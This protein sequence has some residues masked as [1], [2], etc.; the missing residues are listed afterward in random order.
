MVAGVVPCA[1]K[2]ARNAINFE[3]L[4][5][6]SGDQYPNVAAEGA[7]ETARAGV[8]KGSP[9]DCFGVFCQVG[10]L[11]RYQQGC[12]LALISWMRPIDTIPEKETLTY[13]FHHSVQDGILF[14]SC[15]PGHLRKRGTFRDRLMLP[16]VPVNF[17]L[18]SYH[19]HALSRRHLAFKSTHEKIRHRYWWPTI[20]R[21]VR[22]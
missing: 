18:H 20:G 3:S 13:M 7:D 6:L 17:V 14:K 9:R 19:D 11:P 4:V 16:D 15:L 2:T 8:A 12:V 1:A 21:D 5:I 22:R 10:M